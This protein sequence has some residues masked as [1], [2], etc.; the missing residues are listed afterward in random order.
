M[1]RSSWK[2]PF[3]EKSLY[4][5]YIN[6]TVSKKKHLQ[7][8]S[9]S[10]FIPSFLLNKRIL[11]H[12]GNSFRHVSITREKIGFKFGEFSYTRKYIPNSMAVAVLKKKNKGNVTKSKPSNNK[13]SK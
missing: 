12:N 7:I 3:I 11:V 13:K 6:K 4:K 5:K 1:S 10:S 9:R 8:W 2:G